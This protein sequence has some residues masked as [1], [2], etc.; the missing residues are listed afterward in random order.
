M[1]TSSDI[2]EDWV[3]HHITNEPTA[4]QVVEILRQRWGWTILIDDMSRFEEQ[5]NET[6]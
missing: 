1:R 6:L 3:H 4:R 2:L 5:A